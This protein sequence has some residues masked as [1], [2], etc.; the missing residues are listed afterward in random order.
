MT[1]GESKFVKFVEVEGSQMAHYDINDCKNR[2]FLSKAA[3]LRELGN[4]TKAKL[5]LKGKY[6]SDRKFASIAEPPL[7][8]QISGHMEDITKAIKKITVVKDK[9]AGEMLKE[10]EKVIPIEM[11]D[12][13]LDSSFSIRQRLVGTQGTY[14]KYIQNKTFC[15]VQLKG[16]NEKDYL[17]IHLIA[18][19]LEMLKKA[20]ELVL[21]LISTI[22]REYAR[23]VKRRENALRSM[24]SI[25]QMTSRYY[26]PPQ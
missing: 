19:S 18:P 6:T 25:E 23:H 8:I 20:E 1:Q 22:K 16:S 17:G 5:E 10:L 7:Y 4:Q 13:V 12:A 15:T 24:K 26:M 21:D 9:S 2:F 11:R 14:F 3:T